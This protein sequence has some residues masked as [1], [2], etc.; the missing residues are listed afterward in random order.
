MPYVGTTLE[1]HALCWSHCPF[2]TYLGQESVSF[3]ILHSVWEV[4]LCITSSSPS[5]SG[6]IISRHPV[7]KNLELLNPLTVQ[8]EDNFTADK[9]N[10]VYYNK[11]LMRHCMSVCW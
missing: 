7:H 10:E 9:T 4:V 8:F 11:N 6:D 5:L 3:R 1:L 2:S